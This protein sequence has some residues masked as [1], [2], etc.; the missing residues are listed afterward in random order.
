MDLDKIL[1]DG[2]VEVPMMIIDKETPTTI[3]VY[4]V[5]QQQI[6]LIKEKYYPNDE[7]EIVAVNYTQQTESRWIP[8]YDALLLDCYNQLKGNLDL[9][10]S[11]FNLSLYDYDQSTSRKAKRF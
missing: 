11:T 6:P 7:R 9:L 3:F 5:S 2:K 10:A 8:E 4:N 1:G